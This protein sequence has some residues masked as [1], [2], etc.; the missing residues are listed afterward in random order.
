VA[1]IAKTGKPYWLDT[2]TILKERY[3]IEDVVEEGGF[4]IV[5]L[6]WDM[7]LC[8]KVAVKEYFPRELAGRDKGVRAVS[9]YEGRYKQT[10]EYGLEKFLSEARTLASF[11]SMEG[12]IWV[13]DFFYANNTAY[14]IMEYVEGINVKEYVQQNG[15]MKSVKVLEVMRPI[16]LSLEKIHRFGL[17]HRD[18]SP[19]NIVINRE[20]KAYLVDFGIT[21]PYTGEDFRTITVFFKRGYAAEEQYRE[22][23]EQGAWTDV[24][25]V[26]ATMYY[27]LTGVPPVE[28]AQ[29]NIKDVLVPLSSYRKLSIPENVQKAV[30]KGM[31][32]EASKRYAT[33][34]QLYK[35]LYE[36]ENAHGST[37]GNKIRFA[38]LTGLCGI[39]L[40]A[41]FFFGTGEMS[42]RRNLFGG[43]TVREQT[44]PPSAT[45]PAK[46]SETV[47]KPES[48]NATEVPSKNPESGKS[49]AEKT[50]ESEKLYK[51]PNV[52]GKTEKKA[53]QL[54]R[55]IR[56]SFVKLTIKRV[57]HDK[58]AK[59]RV[60]RQ[61]IRAGFQYRQ[62]D[63]QEIVLTVSK[64]KKA[65]KKVPV[66]ATPVPVQTQ[67]PAPAVTP[68]PASK[69]P[70]AKKDNG[71]D[72]AG[73]LP[74]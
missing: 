27:M 61:S 53:K 63:I 13:K 49:G 58:V 10:F 23:G 44:V 26:C 51:M 24:Y 43:D 31:A 52:K 19:E 59:G 71:D 11:N 33:V 17:I 21:R 7:L 34:E 22:K 25:A 60:L 16:L 40:G 5:Y 8:I 74:Y 28:S 15:E 4:G 9:V 35:D 2:G 20:G 69:K 3:R 57:F 68:K 48:P 50:P 37:L 32:V 62:G 46:V 47:S 36:C 70:S 66:K 72:Y 41:V 55:K 14:I 73:I 38:G 12:I 45:E 30:K 39:I 1:K 42:G 6:G 64:G 18:I 67:P 29:R 54:L 56:D 65:A